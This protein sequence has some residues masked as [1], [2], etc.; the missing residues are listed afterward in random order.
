MGRVNI[1]LWWVDSEFVVHP[2]LKSHTGGFTSMP[3]PIILMTHITIAK[4]TL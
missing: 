2:E 4:M 3:D 1:V